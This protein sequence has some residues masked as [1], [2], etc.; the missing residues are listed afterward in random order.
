MSNGK[1]F[2]INFVDL[3]QR[4]RSIPI[5]SCGETNSKLPNS[6]HYILIAAL[7]NTALV[8][9]NGKDAAISCEM[10]LLLLLKQPSPKFAT[11]DIDGRRVVDIS[12]SQTAGGDYSFPV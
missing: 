10:L 5:C 6:G 11:D 2:A 3:Q 7:R 9:D 1:H 12:D 4:S 8:I